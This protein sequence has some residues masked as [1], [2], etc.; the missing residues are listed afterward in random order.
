MDVATIGWLVGWLAQKVLRTFLPRLDA[1]GARATALAALLWR[2][3]H[4]LGVLYCTVLVVVRSSFSQPTNKL[5]LVEAAAAAAAVAAAVRGR[6]EGRTAPLFLL[7]SSSVFGFSLTDEKGKKEKKLLFMILP[8]RGKQGCCG[9]CCSCLAATFVASAV[10]MQRE[11]RR[12]SSSCKLVMYIDSLPPPLLLAFF[13]SL[14]FF[15]C[16]VL[17]SF[18]H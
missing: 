10:Y 12:N 3:W 8:V 1:S 7:H 2:G 11:R 18:E 17:G 13:F 14:F 4:V 5:K 9:C 16:S 15:F 6:K